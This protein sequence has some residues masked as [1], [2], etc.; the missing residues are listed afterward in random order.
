MS[1]DDTAAPHQVAHRGVRRRHPR[2]PITRRSSEPP[3]RLRRSARLARTARLEDAERLR[4]ELGLS[5]RLARALRRRRRLVVRRGQLAKQ[6]RGRHAPVRV[7]DDAFALQKRALALD[8][9]RGRAPLAAEAAQPPVRR[10][11]SLS[12]HA[13][14]GRAVLAHTSADGPRAAARYFG[15]GPIRRHLAGRD[16]THDRV[17]LGLE[18]GRHFSQVLRVDDANAYGFE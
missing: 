11:D 12:R 2:P 15:H 3:R 1:H 16:S 17:D 9:R 7:E 14:L 10:D 13:G 18:G 8:R 6:A 5:R 4:R